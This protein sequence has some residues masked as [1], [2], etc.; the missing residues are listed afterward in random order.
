[1]TAA[2]GN[3]RFA[4]RFYTATEIDGTLEFNYILNT[5][6]KSIVIKPTLS[7]DFTNVNVIKNNADISFFLNSVTRSQNPSY[8]IPSQV[9]F[10]DV[11]PSTAAILLEADDSLG[12]KANELKLEAEAYTSDGGDIIYNWYYIAPGYRPYVPYDETGAETAWPT[13]RPSMKLYVKND[14]YVEG[15]TNPEEKNQYIEFTGAWPKTEPDAN[16]LVLY[17]LNPV[18]KVQDNNDFSIETKYSEYKPNTWPVE[19]PLGLNVWVKDTTV[20]PV[21]YKR[22][23]QNE[24]WPVFVNNAQEKE[25]L[26]AKVGKEVLTTLD[27]TLYTYKTVL[28]FED[29]TTDVTGQYFV[30]GTNQVLDFDNIKVINSVYTDAPANYCSILAPIPVKI[31]EGKDL[32]SHMFLTDKNNSL[33]ITINK[34][35]ANPQRFYNLYYSNTHFSDIKNIPANDEENG[36]VTTI[37]QLVP[38]TNNDT[39][40]KYAIPNEKFGYYAI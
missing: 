23:G 19:R 11:P 8:A 32:P 7:V 14:K 35:D 10:S 33:Q 39:I 5:V 17:V 25:E 37:T 4:V 27:I 15:S 13:Q 3:L 12:L 2:A 38:V 24:P 21:V 30:R 9:V 6:P 29:T 26:E 28:K 36:I 16:T 18:R 1:M 20:T 40:I 22:Y 34:D 31:E